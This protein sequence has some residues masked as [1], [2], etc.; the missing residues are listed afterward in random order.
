VDNTCTSALNVIESESIC[1]WA[2]VMILW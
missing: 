2:L 1:L